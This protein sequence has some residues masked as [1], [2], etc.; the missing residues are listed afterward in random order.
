MRERTF[1][2]FNAVALA[3]MYF[4]PA[5]PLIGVA[6]LATCAALCMTSFL[7][8]KDAPG[9]PAYGLLGSLLLFS[10]LFALVT[11][12]EVTMRG[13][14]AD[15]VEGSIWLGCGLWAFWIFRVSWRKREAAESTDG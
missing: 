14:L 9:N 6:V 4:V 7:R 12:P 3:A 15:V 2:L 1:W 5:F 8:D 10:G 13:L 11:Y